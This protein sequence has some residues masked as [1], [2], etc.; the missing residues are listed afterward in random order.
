MLSV[1]EWFDLVLQ[2]GV[3]VVIVLFDEPRQNQGS[4]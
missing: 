4:C 1:F 3:F 2:F